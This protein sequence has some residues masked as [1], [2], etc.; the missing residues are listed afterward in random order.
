[1]AL[2]TAGVFEGRLGD[3]L[4]WDQEE[5]VWF[6]DNRSSHTLGEQLLLTDGIYVH[7]GQKFKH[8]RT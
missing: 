3:T 4:D 6:N 7:L 2:N 5:I 8:R 1:M